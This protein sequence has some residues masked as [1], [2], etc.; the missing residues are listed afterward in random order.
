MGTTFTQKVTS[1]VGRIEEPQT[2]EFVR[3]ALME[4]T[5]MEWLKKYV[6]SRFLVASPSNLSYSNAIGFILIKPKSKD[7]GLVEIRQSSVYDREDVYI[8][9]QQATQ[10]YYLSYPCKTDERL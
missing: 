3:Q 5:T 6:N 9:A 2:P 4:K 10:V 1:R 7:V 8:V